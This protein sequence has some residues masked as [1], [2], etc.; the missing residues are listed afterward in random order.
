MTWDA[1]VIGGGHNGL[2]CAAYLA[3][4]GRKV[5][6]LER[7]HLVGGAAVSEEIV[8][9]FTFT[10]CSYVVSL[11]RPQI[12]RDLKLSKHGL[13]MVPLESTFTPYEDGR[14]MA[15][16]ADPHRNWEEIRQFSE[17]DAEVYPQFSLAMGKLARFAKAIIDQPAPDPTSF[18]PKD[19]MQMLGLGRHV[20]ELGDD[21][22]ALQFKLTTMSATDF[23]R[24]WFEADQLI[25][26]MSCSGIIGTMLGVMSPGSAYVLLHHYMGEIDGASRAWAFPKGGTGAV[27]RAIAAAAESYGVEIRTNAGVERILMENGH[28]TGVV[29]EGSGDILRA[30][31]IVSGC[32]PRRT[33]L[34]FVGESHLPSEFAASIKRYRY[35]GSSGK[36]NLALDR[37]PEFACRPGHRHLMGDANISPSTDYLERAFDEAKY[38]DFST[39]PFMNILYPTLLDPSMAPPGKHVMSIFVQYAP[40]A[41]KE[42]PEHWPER[43][44]AF[45]KAVIDTLADYCPTIREDIVGMQVLTPWDLE[46]EFG[47]T[48]GNIFHGELALEQLLFQR[49][50]SGWA[51]YRTPV[52]NLWLAASGAHPGGGIMGAPGHLAAMTMLTE[53]AV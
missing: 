19:L 18:R 24:E 30:R 27:S 22:E 50:T 26:P 49:P 41:I 9:G 51:R 28:A 31:T 6:V 43:R 3:R 15:R 14:S 7:R 46:Q 40:Y 45:G 21:L 16:W 53:G 52:P 4:A 35:R 39:R 12:I 33:F 1:I 37:L 25:A 42:G 11:L 38:G 5:L 10:V 23:L 13:E 8:P 2:T 47:L 34:G 20:R 36:V 17:R 29:L 32:D 44:D 48:E